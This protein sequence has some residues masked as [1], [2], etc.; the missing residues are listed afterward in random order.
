MANDCCKLQSHLLS[1]SDPKA[2][3]SIRRISV[4]R[5]KIFSGH[6]SFH[7]AP[8]DLICI[9]KSQ[10]LNISV[11]PGQSTTLERAHSKLHF[12]VFSTFANFKHLL[13][14][15]EPTFQSDYTF[16]PLKRVRLAIHKFSYYEQPC[17][18]GTTGFENDPVPY[19]L[20]SGT[21]CN[22]P[23]I[24]SQR[25]GNIGV[26]RQSTTIKLMLLVYKLLML[27]IKVNAAS[28]KVINA[29]RL[30]LLK[31]FLLLRN[32]IYRSGIQQEVSYNWDNKWYQSLLL[33]DMDQDYAHIVATSKVHM[34]K[35]DKAQRRL[36]VKDRSTL[37][38]GIPNE[39]QLKFNFIKDAKLLLE[40]IEK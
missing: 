35:L 31:E 12:V 36:E 6:H 37:M 18:S 29:Q 39:H 4:A 40:A 32:S 22:T 13:H 9:S 33:E 17:I 1:E 23:K 10:S 34:L 15:F 3:V 30:R 21:I 8:G 25:N 20:G 26:L 24:E 16:S 5:G 19:N 11:P 28:T 38:M 27:V 7:V 2:L 14:L